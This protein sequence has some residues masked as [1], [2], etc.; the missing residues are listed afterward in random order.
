MADDAADRR[1]PTRPIRVPL[2]M[3]EAYGRVCDRMGIS[4]TED[5]LNHMRRRIQ[6]HGTEEDLSG[7]RTA[8]DE[9][10]ERRSRRGGRPPKQ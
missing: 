8:E 4:R 10:A 5:L 2:A 7:L 9:L 3:W 1:T 6:E